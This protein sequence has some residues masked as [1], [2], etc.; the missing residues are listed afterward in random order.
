MCFG[1]PVGKRKTVSTRGKSDLHVKRPKY[2]W[3]SRWLSNTFIMMRQKA[4]CVK[5]DGQIMESFFEPSKLRPHYLSNT[6]ISQTK[7]YRLTPIFSSVFFAFTDSVFQP[8]VL[9]SKTPDAD[10]CKTF[11]SQSGFTKRMVLGLN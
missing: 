11:N 8:T 5:N 6:T 4:Y 3:H 9:P 7:F 10:W 2:L 1:P